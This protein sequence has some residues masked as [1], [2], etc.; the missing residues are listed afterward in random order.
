MSTTQVLIVSLALLAAITVVAYTHYRTRADELDTTR[1]REERVAAADIADR[2]DRRAAAALERD[3]RVPPGPSEGATLVIH[4]AGRD[5]QGTRVRAGDPETDGWIVVDDASFVTG[6]RA[7]PLG[8]A[9]WFREG[10][11]MW[12]Q[13]L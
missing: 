6:D 8:G 4:V 3:S 13:E 5:V 2:A 12:I 7:Q 10:P 9:Q 11:G 1:A